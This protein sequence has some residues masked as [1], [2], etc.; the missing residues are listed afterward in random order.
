MVINLLLK[1]QKSDKMKKFNII[2]FVLLLSIGLVSCEDEMG[3]KINPGAED[4]TLTFQLNQP[5]YSNLT[6]VLDEENADADMDT[7]TCMQPDYGFTAAVTYTAQV[8]FTES[9]TE[10]DYINLGTTVNGEKVNLVTSE[11]NTAIHDLYGGGFPDPIV[12]VDVYIRLMATVSDATSD[13]AGTV[14][15]VQPLYS[16]AIKLSVQPYFYQDLKSYTDVTPAPY[17][18][19]GMADGAWNNDNSGLGISIFP[20]SVVSGDKYDSNGNGEFTYTGYFQSSVGFKLIRDIGSWSE[21]WGSSDGA[22]DIVHNDGGSSDIKVPNDGYYTIVLNSIDNTLTITASALTPDEY[23]SISMI[24]DVTS[25]AT[26]VVLNPAESSH[27]HIWYGTYTFPANAASDGGIKFRSTG[28]WD[29]DWGAASFPVGIATSG[30]KNILY[31]AGTYV[32][33]FNDIDGSYYF[34]EQ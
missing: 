18:I 20:L 21:Q 32:M 12:P 3:V 19:I 30:G 9:F 31:Q 2:Y 34:I 24:G 33:I 1:H 29:A 28:S 27:N 23:S 11:I 6:Y 26:D 5:V 14:L 10:D 16:N 15:N 22:M 13:I 7:L 17:Y 4:G 8:S 25:W